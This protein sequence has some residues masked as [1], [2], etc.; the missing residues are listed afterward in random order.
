MGGTVD[1]Y[2]NMFDRSRLEFHN[3]VDFK[4]YY[5]KLNSLNLHIGLAPIEDNK[6]NCSKCLVGGTMIVTSDGIQTIEDLRTKYNK[7]K[8]WQ[9]TDF[10]KVSNF[11]EYKKQKTIKLITKNGYEIEGTLHHKLRSSGT[12]I[13]MQN[14]VIGDKVDISFYKFPKVPYQRISAPFFS[15]YIDKD[16]IDFS[17]IDTDLLPKVEINERWGRFLG[18]LLGD[19]C[20]GWSNAIKVS[21]DAQ[22]QDIIDDLLKLGKQLGLNPFI[23]IKKDKDKRAS[24]RARDVAF[25]SKS[26]RYFLGESIGFTGRKEKN[27]V[28]PDVIF[29]SPKSV[30]AAFI[31]GLFETDGCVTGGGCSFTTKNKKLAQQIQFLLLGFGIKSKIIINTVHEA[32]GRHYGRQ[33]YTLHLGRQAC[34]IFYLEIGFTSKIKQEKLENIYNKSHSNKYKEWE[35]NEEIIRIENSEN[36]VFDIEIPDN[37]YYLA[38]GIISHNSSLRFLEYSLC[39]AATIASDVYPYN[40]VIES[41]KD[42]IIVKKNKHLEWVK[43]LSLLIE[44]PNKITELCSN[45]QIKI[46]EKYDYYKNIGSWINVYNEVLGERKRV[47]INSE[48]STDYTYTRPE[49]KGKKEIQVLSQ[50]PSMEGMVPELLKHTEINES[51]IKNILIVKLDHLGDVI[52]TIP[53]MRMV[54][55]KFPDANITLLCGNY[56]KAIAER[57]PYIDDIVTFDF[58]NERSENGQRQFTQEEL[59]DLHKMCTSKEFDLA[60]DLRRHPETRGILSFTNA[61][62]KIGY[63][64][65][66]NNYDF[67]TTCVKI[68][69]NV[70]DKKGPAGILKPHITAQICHMIKSVFKDIPNEIPEIELRLKDSDNKV[71]EKYPQLLNNGNIICIHPGTGAPVRQ[72]PVEYYAELCNLFIEKDDAII[73][74]VGAK[75]ERGLADLTYNKI[76]KKENVVMLCGEIGLGEFLTVLPKCKL[77][78][79]NNSGPSHMAGISK[80]PTLVTFS[81]QVSPYEWQ[82]LGPKTV[83]VRTDMECAPCS[84]GRPEQCFW[85]L[86][87]LRFIKPEVVYSESTKFIGGV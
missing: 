63:W 55:N 5:D 15:T 53:A 65:Y 23:T 19:G 14:F 69:D 26:L 61:K 17:E 87:C 68:P 59:K 37:H 57:I 79:G 18:Y 58:F 82:P 31:S 16:R 42:G 21:C 24:E 83:L 80:V 1:K 86:E 62:Y 40:N 76:N 32:F 84:L 46:K 2:L 7:T 74:L 85:N 39:G 70:H 11:F 28:V 25:C 36:D 20:I 38:N 78:I 64:F 13:E 8:V 73:L 43:S 45:S 72:W 27:L 47:I 49:Y 66:Q 29:K 4:D 52:L 33:Y 12:F 3:W 51:E 10:K 22:Y 34:D 50:T 71:F 60:I 35:L 44:N 9:E 6:F 67:L 54:R 30:I 77:F 48:V 41:G 81:G 56:A 75:A